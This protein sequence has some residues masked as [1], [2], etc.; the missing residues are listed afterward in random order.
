MFYLYRRATYMCNDTVYEKKQDNYEI[1]AGSPEVF[2][3]VIS[4]FVFYL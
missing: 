3:F 4:V 1:M 2:S